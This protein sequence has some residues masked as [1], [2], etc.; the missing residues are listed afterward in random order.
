VDAWWR[1]R[2]QPEQGPVWV[3]PWPLRLLFVQ[4][5]LIYFCNGLYKLFGSDWWSGRA[6]YYVLGDLTLTRWSYAAAPVP[7][8]LTRLLTWTVLAWEVSFPLLLCWRPARL[9][10]LGFGV[11]FHLTLAVS[12]ELGCFSLY[13]LCLY[14]PLVPW[15]RITAVRRGPVPTEPHP[16]A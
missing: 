10:A 9:V 2:R 3:Y 4:M 13:M 15:E 12:V 16:R 1:R 11:L 6:L 8:G 14:L 5:V 7:L